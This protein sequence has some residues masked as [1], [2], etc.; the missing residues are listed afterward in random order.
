MHG[1]AVVVSGC[2]SGG[3][4]KGLF[5]ALSRTGALEAYLG[6]NVPLQKPSA[7]MECVYDHKGVRIGTVGEVDS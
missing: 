3:M 7:L 4:P 1:G 2:L 5:E 6:W